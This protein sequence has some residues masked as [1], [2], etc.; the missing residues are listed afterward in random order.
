[1][2]DTFI[3]FLQ[4]EKID[5]AIIAA[6]ACAVML[7]IFFKGIPYGH[8]MTHHFQCAYS[9][10]EGFSAGDFYPSWSA[11]RNLG[12]GG[13]ELRLLQLDSL[14]R[15]DAI[16]SVLQDF[17]TKAGRCPNDWREVFPLLRTIL[18]PNGD[19]L[20]VDEKTLAPVDPTDIPY[21]LDRK[22]GKCDIR[23]D[24]TKS[25]IPTL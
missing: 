20:S 18:L 3:K 14:V 21:I 8:D 10:Y 12:Y 17:Q 5:A 25:K 9:Y 19:S 7:P 23:I 16:R 2:K 11:I 24:F 6:I 15:E 4:N 1:M 13:M 22:A